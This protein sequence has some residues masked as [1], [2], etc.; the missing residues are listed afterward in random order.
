MC[1]Y[2][3]LNK[4]IAPNGVLNFFLFKNARESIINYGVGSK[5]NEDK[6]KRLTM[7]SVTGGLNS[8]SGCQVISTYKLL[9]IL[10]VPGRYVPHY[11]RYRVGRHWLLILTLKLVTAELI[12]TFI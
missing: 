6:E 7:L 3:S 12:S 10:L 11:L 9:C 8:C 5:H 1:I 2:F 4:F